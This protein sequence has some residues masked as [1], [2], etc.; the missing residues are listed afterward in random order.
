MHRLCR[1]HR[2]VLRGGN[3]KGSQA[4]DEI[5]EPS[6]HPRRTDNERAVQSKVRNRISEG[7]L[8][9]EKMGLDDFKAV[10]DPVD[11][12]QQ[13]DLVGRS[14]RRLRKMQ[15]DLGLDPGLGQVTDGQPRGR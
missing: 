2:T 6:D 3:C 1:L 4:T 8:P 11:R 14:A 12:R 10:G 5:I 15:D 9:V 7:E 13:F